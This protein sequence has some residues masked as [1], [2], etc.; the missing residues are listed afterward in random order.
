M[1]GRATSGLH[2]LAVGLSAAIVGLIAAG[3]LVKSREAGLAVPDWP[4]SYGSLNPPRWWQIENVRAEHGHR[5]LAGAVAL[6][7]LGLAL[8]AQRRE[9]RRAVRGLAWAAVGAVL[10]QAA[11]GG[12]TVLLFLPPLVS[13]SHA[14]LAELFLCVVV[15]LAVVTGPAWPA[16]AADPGREVPFRVRGLAAALPLLVFVQILLGAAVRHL[17]AGL[18]IPDFPLV[19]GGLLPSH[20]SPA[21]ALHFAHRVGAAVVLVLVVAIALELRRRGWA[22]SGLATPASALLVLTLTQ[23]CFGGAVVWSG[24]AV[25]PNTAHVAVGASLLAVSVV[26]ALNAWQEALAVR[27]AGASRVPVEAPPRPAAALSG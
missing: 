12:V 10:L 20:W 9:P 14:A 23:I 15:T 26:L 3:A 1:P 11:L 25:A 19:F 27:L 7:T 24:R 21:I 18:A 13:I 17:G 2:R 8:W 5:L 4:L 16:T 6:A 22:G